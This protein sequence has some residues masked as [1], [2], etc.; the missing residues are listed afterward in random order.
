MGMLMR[1]V[2]GMALGSGS[3]SKAAGSGC[4]ANTTSAG[5]GCNNKFRRA[6]TASSGEV[7]F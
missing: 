2:G 5:S 4:R 7:M 1:L 6:T 3:G